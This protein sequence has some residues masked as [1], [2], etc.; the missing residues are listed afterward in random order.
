MN[1]KAVLAFVL[2]CLL[3]GGCALQAAEKAKEKSPRMELNVAM[4]IAGG[5]VGLC[6]SVGYFLIKRFVSVEGNFSVITKLFPLCANLTLQL[7]LWKFI[8][9]VTGGVGLSPMGGGVSN[10]GVGL[11]FRV[12]RQTG[13]LVEYRT[14]NGTVG[15][16]KK[17]MN[18]IGAGISYLF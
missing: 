11:K 9:Y 8:P 6:K 16:R 17:T 1:K 5:Q 14:Y 10:A 15:I 18:L 3:A 4:G 12:T 7:P 13:I 2:A